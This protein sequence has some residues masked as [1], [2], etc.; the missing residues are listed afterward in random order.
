[1][2]REVGVTADGETG[3]VERKKNVKNMPTVW[4]KFGLSVLPIGIKMG[5]IS[6]KV[7]DV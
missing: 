5:T 1:M 7:T 2:Y 3:D 6:K 4:R